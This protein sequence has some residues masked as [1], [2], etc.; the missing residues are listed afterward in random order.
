[1]DSSVVVAAAVG[2]PGPR[3]AA[4]RVIADRPLI[5][6]HAA[7][8]A[9]SVLTRLPGAYRMTAADARRFVRES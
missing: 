2:P 1:M 4:Q 9:Y 6:F 7:L 3:A 8:E 5:A